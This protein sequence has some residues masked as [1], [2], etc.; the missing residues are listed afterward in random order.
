MKLPGALRRGSLREKP[1]R[2]LLARKLCLRR[3]L[4]PPAMSGKARYCLAIHCLTVNCLNPPAL[5]FTPTAKCGLWLFPVDGQFW[6]LV[7]RQ[8]GPNGK[9][10][11]CKQV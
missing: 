7:N 1:V 8:K 3:G 2:A 5:P 6:L 11:H 4:P 10:W 9:L